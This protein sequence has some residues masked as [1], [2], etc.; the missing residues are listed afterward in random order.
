MVKNGLEGKIAKVN[1]QK[2]LNAKQRQQ[3]KEKHTQHQIK[4][5][6][7]YLF[8]LAFILY[9]ESGFSFYFFNFL[10]K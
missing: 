6:Q 10:I 2:M 7:T 3:E 4:G 1:E 9:F 5:N 8:F